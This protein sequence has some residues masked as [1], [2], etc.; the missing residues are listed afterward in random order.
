MLNIHIQVHTRKEYKKK[1]KKTVESNQ[2]KKI[3]LFAEQEAVHIV[4]KN[5][6]QYIL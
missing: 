4:L 6:E 2:N 1:E 3:I 5:S